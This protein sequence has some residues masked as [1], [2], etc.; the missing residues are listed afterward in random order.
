[1]IECPGCGTYV[2]DGT[3]DQLTETTENVF[4]CPSTARILCS[5]NYHVCTSAEEAKTLGF[6]GDSDTDCSDTVVTVGNMNYLT[7]ES[8]TF[9][10]VLCCANEPEPL[11]TTTGV[12]TTMVDE[13]IEPE[14]CEDNTCDC[15]DDEYCQNCQPHGFCSQCING[16][17][18]LKWNYPCANC[19]EVFGIG[20]MFCQNNNGCGQCKNGYT[21]TYDSDAN[22]WYCQ[23]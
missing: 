3:C 19:Q 18:K 16:Y 14:P 9:N 11:P 21:R 5:D 6:N 2:V 22:I 1:M 13:W 8:N 17:F 23:S 20:C 12:A 7:G 10:G 15:N 4:A